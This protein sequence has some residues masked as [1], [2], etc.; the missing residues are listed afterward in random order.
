LG[1]DELW[2]KLWRR[3]IGDAFELKEDASHRL[4]DLVVEPSGNPQP[5][6]LLGREGA[7]PALDAF[8]LKPIKHLV[9]G[10]HELPNL[11]WPGCRNP[12]SRT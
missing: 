10:A 9:E 2:A 7:L 3:F 12:L 6:R 1:F 5:L 8:A 4:P 11:A